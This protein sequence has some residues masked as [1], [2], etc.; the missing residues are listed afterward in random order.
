V[1]SAVVKN[2]RI[3]EAEILNIAKSKIQNEEIVRLICMN[4]DW[5]KVYP[6]RKALVENSK[7]PLPQALR[8]VS[9]LTV[10]DLSS[11][12][13]SRNVQ[14]VISTQARRMLS[15]KKKD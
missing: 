9:S 7:T 1:S 13:K 8:F 6:I 14:T 5:L 2:P 11:L 10:K 4:K 3:T 12:A 15:A